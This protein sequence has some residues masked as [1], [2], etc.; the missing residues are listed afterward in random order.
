[1]RQV[2]ER[3][4]RK[5][6]Y[7]DAKPEEYEFRLDGKLVRKDRFESA[8]AQI[9]DLVGFDPR[10]GWELDDLV[11]AVRRL[12]EQRGETDEG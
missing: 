4:F 7:L 11:S 5:P 8:I 1:M 6:E 9:H 2:T 10:S 12:V 3:D